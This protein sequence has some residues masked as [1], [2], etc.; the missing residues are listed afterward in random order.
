MDGTR[1]PAIPSS[2]R[3]TR[4]ALNSCAVMICSAGVVPPP[5]AALLVASGDFRYQMTDPDAWHYVRALH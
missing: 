1:K 4:P 3:R 2:G 5:V